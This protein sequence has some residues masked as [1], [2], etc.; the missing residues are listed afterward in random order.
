MNSARLRI[1]KKVRKGVDKMSQIGTVK[2]FSR[3]GNKPKGRTRPQN[4]STSGRD[5][6]DLQAWLQRSKY[7]D[8]KFWAPPDVLASREECVAEVVTAVTRF[9]ATGLLLAGDSGAKAAEKAAK[10]RGR[11]TRLKWAKEA[12]KK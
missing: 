11:N 12:V 5:R 4:G 9:D 6:K 10:L 3:H 7:E 8:V 2:C 1:V